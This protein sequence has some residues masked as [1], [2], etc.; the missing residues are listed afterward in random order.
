MVTPYLKPS[1]LKNVVGRVR[2]VEVFKDGSILIL[3]DEQD[4]GLFRIS[5]VK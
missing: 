2:D 3:N 5:R 1:I 4:G